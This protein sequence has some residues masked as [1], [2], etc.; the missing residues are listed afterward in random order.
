LLPAPVVIQAFGRDGKVMHRVRIGP[1]E[2]GETMAA[3]N[4]ALLLE[5]ISATGLITE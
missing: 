3:V 2:D 4:A 1:L 5:N